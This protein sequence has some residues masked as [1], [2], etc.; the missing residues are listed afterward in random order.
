MSYR[1]VV[2]LREHTHL[3]CWTTLKNDGG[4]LHRK[5]T[6]LLLWGT[7]S[8]SIVNYLTH[9]QKSV[10]QRQHCLHQ[11]MGNLLLRSEPIK[12]VKTAVRQMCPWQLKCL[13]FHNPGRQPEHQSRGR[14]GSLQYTSVHWHR[15]DPSPTPN[16][17][18]VHTKSYYRSAGCIPT[19]SNGSQIDSVWIVR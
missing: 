14:L 18:H 9:H 16:H 5:I 19:P 15:T 2:W 3:I 6:R 11:F 10:F 13:Q 4:L 12:A 1:L 8:P 7:M 17:V